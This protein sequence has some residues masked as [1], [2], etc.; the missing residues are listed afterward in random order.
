VETVKA[1]MGLRGRPFYVVSRA[2]EVDRIILV[3]PSGFIR[4]HRG[5]ANLAA[6]PTFVGR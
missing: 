2:G 3:E 5:G 4:I 1:A 6:S